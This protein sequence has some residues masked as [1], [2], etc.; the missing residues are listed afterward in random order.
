[1]GFV[2]QGFASSC[3]TFAAQRDPKSA[4]SFA[5]LA[6]LPVTNAAQCDVWLNSI[7]KACSDHPGNRVSAG[8]TVVRRLC[9]V[10]SSPGGTVAT[11]A[12]LTLLWL[13][14]VRALFCD[15]HTPIDC[16]NLDA[17][18]LLLCGGNLTAFVTA[19]GLELFLEAAHRYIP[20]EGVAFLIIDLMFR[21][22]NH[23]AEMKSAVLSRGSVDVVLAVLS[24]HLHS[25]RV[26][27]I[28]F[29]VL[30]Y[31]CHPIPGV[32]ATWPCSTIVKVPLAGDVRDAI[33][34]RGGLSRLYAG[35][36]T[37]PSSV[38]VQ[39]G[40]CQALA[41]LSAGTNALRV[42]TTGGLA[43]IFNA[44]KALPASP[45]V[46]QAACEALRNA[47]EAAL[48]A[49]LES[50]VIADAATAAT[51]VS[52]ER[53]SLVYAAMD[54]HAAVDRI[55]GAACGVL[56]SL[57]FNPQNHFVIVCS[58]GL[59]RLYGAM[60]AHPGLESLQEE[61]VAALMCLSGRPINVPIMKAGR[62]VA[63]IRKAM[64]N[65]PGNESIMSQGR[66]ALAA[67]R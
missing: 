47:V 40:A 66:E 22:V 46:Q 58:G 23:T 42:V 14:T 57:A 50:R 1:M 12:E 37:H 11:S 61:A 16:R 38:F 18:G 24:T 60:S 49:S 54:N 65:H 29:G 56:Q 51:L 55:Q 64:S 45:D 28:S 4:A 9:E 15:V 59:D 33:A 13:R 17:P 39:A 62:A 35:M 3:K 19:G 32:A 31:S 36:D 2:L 53:L 10:M 21:L 27:T 5:K 8:P 6:R 52:A 26:Q 25:E 20:N 44:M 7:G 43:R 48:L 63:L 67:L 34:F 30:L 41:K